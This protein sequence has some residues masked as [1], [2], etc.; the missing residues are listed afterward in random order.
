MK[1]ELNMKSQFND[2]SRFQGTE[3]DLG[4]GLLSAA[5]LAGAG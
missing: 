3:A 1:E 5:V 4:R 2:F